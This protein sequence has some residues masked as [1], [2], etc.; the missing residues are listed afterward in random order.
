[1]EKI[2]S[3]TP[4][5]SGDSGG[6]SEAALN[7]LRRP[8]E[9]QFSTEKTLLP[10]ASARNFVELSEE[11]LH[12]LSLFINDGHQLEKGWPGLAQ[13]MAQIPES[14]CFSR[15]REL[16]LKNLLYYQAEIAELEAELRRVENA[17]ARK[18]GPE[19]EYATDPSKMLI[20]ASTDRRNASPEEQRQGELVLKIRERLREYSK[21]VGPQR[22]RSNR[23]LM[24]PPG[25]TR[26]SSNT[27]RFQ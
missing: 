17:D 4:A 7:A 12:E 14:A 6:L 24:T 26:L 13:M 1:M 18:S 3:S 16:N 20:S 21:I 8:S 9:T 10:T 5:K 23:A 15:F 11:A 2:V 25:Q 19:G 22:L 27:P